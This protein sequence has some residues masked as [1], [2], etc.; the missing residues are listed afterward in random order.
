MKL[1][2]VRLKPFKLNYTIILLDVA[3]QLHL[4]C[5][6]IQFNFLI[7]V[8]FL[9]QSFFDTTFYFY[10]PQFWDEIYLYNA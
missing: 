7:Y 4:K 3:A 8:C 9:N 5:K 1:T 10:N 6:G 2:N